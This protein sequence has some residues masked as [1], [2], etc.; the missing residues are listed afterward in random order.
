MTSTTDKAETA[1]LVDRP[2]PSVDFQ[3]GIW[4]CGG[5][6]AKIEGEDLAEDLGLAGF[7]GVLGFAADHAWADRRGDLRA[8][9][10]AA[11]Q[12]I[13]HDAEEGFFGEV[14]V[15]AVVFFA[16]EGCELARVEGSDLRLT[17]DFAGDKCEGDTVHVAEEVGAVC[18]AEELLDLQRSGIELV[19]VFS[20]SGNFL[21]FQI[22]RNAHRRP[23]KF[24]GS[25][26]SSIE[27]VGR[28][29]RV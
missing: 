6:T 29:G 13:A 19:A 24:S 22:V 25:P 10:R 8:T 4:G 21:S 17:D 18:A 23:D 28:S 7:A 15:L 20:L 26:D 9:G 11:V 14:A 2:A 1:A 16:H 12:E 3:D 5:T 27:L